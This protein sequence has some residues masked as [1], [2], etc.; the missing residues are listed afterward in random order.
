MLVT[1]ENFTKTYI[2]SVIKKIR[3]VFKNLRGISNQCIISTSPILSE[4]QF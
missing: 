1:L 2:S 3:K 4:I